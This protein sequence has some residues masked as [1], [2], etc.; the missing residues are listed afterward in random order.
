[1]CRAVH[2][3]SIESGNGGT[4]N[5]SSVIG[6]VKHAVRTIHLYWLAPPTQRTSRTFF[7]LAATKRV[8]FQRIAVFR[9]CCSRVDFN[10]SFTLFQVVTTGINGMRNWT[11]CFRV[12]SSTS[13]L[14]TDRESLPRFPHFPSLPISAIIDRARQLHNFPSKN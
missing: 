14:G 2:S 10:M 11:T 7:S 12:L 3:Q 8:C 13:G 5:P 6:E 1:M 9:S 4:T